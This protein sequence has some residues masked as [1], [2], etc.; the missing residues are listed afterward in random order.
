MLLH[1]LLFLSISPLLLVIPTLAFVSAF[2][3]LE[4][5]PATGLAFF[6]AIWFL[7]LDWAGEVDF[8]LELSAVLQYWSSKA[9]RES[10]VFEDWEVEIVRIRW[11]LATFI[12]VEE[13]ALFPLCTGNALLVALGLIV[14]L[15]FCTTWD[16]FKKYEK[17]LGPKF[18]TWIV[19]HV[20]CTLQFTQRMLQKP[21]LA[22]FSCATY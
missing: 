7:L 9:W 4:V 17:I 5:L 15:S 22:L 1:L 3:V 8:A 18:N 19:L 20:P 2:W 13:D 12:P 10:D 14:F 21:F 6:C 16:I 11:P